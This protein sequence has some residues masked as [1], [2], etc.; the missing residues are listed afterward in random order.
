MKLICLCNSKE[1]KLKPS[2]SDTFHDFKFTVLNGFKSLM[3]QLLILIL[4][5]KVLV[6]NSVAL[7][8]NPKKSKA[9]S[10]FLL[11]HDR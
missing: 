8:N 6:F 7:T 3:S 4:F 5:D 11:Q 1:F 9:K 10:K 2:S